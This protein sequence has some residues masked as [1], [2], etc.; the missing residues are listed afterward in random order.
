M[1]D[2]VISIEGTIMGCR[3]G[4]FKAPDGG[5]EEPFGVVQMIGRDATAV[6]VFDISLA[7]GFD[8]ARYPTGG[9]MKIPVRVGASKDGK[10]IYFRE[11]VAAAPTD[12]APKQARARGEEPRTQPPAAGKL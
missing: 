3:T 9:K 8:I 7:E 2:A 11:V 1:T 12:D 5:K 4:V 10:R 6:R